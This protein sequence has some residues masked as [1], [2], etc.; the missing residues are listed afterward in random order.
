MLPKKSCECDIPGMSGCTIGSSGP[1]W[2]YLQAL[3]NGIGTAGA[4]G[5]SFAIFGAL[6]ARGVFAAVAVVAL[7]G[8]FAATA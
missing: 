7:S 3:T 5:A 1:R 2:L 8:G 6:L 4:A